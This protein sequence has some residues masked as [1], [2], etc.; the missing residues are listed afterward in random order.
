MSKPSDH[1]VPG[2]LCIRCEQ[3]PAVAL[4]RLVTATDAQ[5]RNIL[6]WGGATCEPCALDLADVL[7]REVGK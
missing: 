2:A 7:K 1:I 3:R 4:T 5:P 6:L